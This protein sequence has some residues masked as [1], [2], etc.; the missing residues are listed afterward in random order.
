MRT[1]DITR[2]RQP[3]TGPSFVLIARVIESE[4]RLEY[5]LTQIRRDAGTIVIDR[6]RKIAM[7]AMTDDRDR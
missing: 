1:R 4:K 7:I 2:D 6:D 5:F 3:K